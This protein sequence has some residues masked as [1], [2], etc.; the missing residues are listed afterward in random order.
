MFSFKQDEARA[1]FEQKF[2]IFVKNATFVY[3]SFILV[4]RD[5]VGEFFELIN[6]FANIEPAEDEREVLES[7]SSTVVNCANYM[8]YVEPEV[9]VS[10]EPISSEEVAKEKHMQFVKKKPFPRWHNYATDIIDFLSN[11][12]KSYLFNIHDPSVKGLTKITATLHSNRYCYFNEFAKD[13]KNLLDSVMRKLKS[14]KRN[15]KNIL[16]CEGTIARFTKTIEK[17]KNQGKI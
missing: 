11:S 9:F 16:F 13:A 7:P 14:K 12:R 17:L 6:N 8:P 3:H 2:Q 1:E 15:E 4:P 10:R 5:C